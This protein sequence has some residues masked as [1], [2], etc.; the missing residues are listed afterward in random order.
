MWERYREDGLVVLGVPSND[1]G[2][3]E[4][5]SEEEI[6]A[7]CQANYLVDFPMTSKQVVSGSEAHPLYLWLAGELGQATTPRWN[8]HKYLIGPD[9]SALQ[10]WST[11]V[12]PMSEDVIDA[13]EGA[14]EQ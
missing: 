7:F 4:P 10:T 5:G 13:I 12:A 2:A 11:R 8:F 1:F 9:G 14:L 3:Q 6:K